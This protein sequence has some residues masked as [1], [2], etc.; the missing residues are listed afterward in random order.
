M[1]DGTKCQYLEAGLRVTCASAKETFVPALERIHD[2]FVDAEIESL[3]A[4]V[5]VDGVGL[6]AIAYRGHLFDLD[7]T[8]RARRFEPRLDG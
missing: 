4:E 1:A 3:A 7:R 2:R 8:L 5:D 6:A